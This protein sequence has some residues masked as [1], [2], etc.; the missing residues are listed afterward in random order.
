M[1]KKDPGSY[2]VCSSPSPALAPERL[3]TA[4]GGIETATHCLDLSAV[5]W[6][7]VGAEHWEHAKGLLNEARR[8][9]AQAMAV[10]K[11]YHKD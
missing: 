3:R 4:L 6:R 11:T 9:L 10:W 8:A 5:P 1:S 7:P 2:E